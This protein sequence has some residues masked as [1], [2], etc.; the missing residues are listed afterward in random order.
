M[1]K[2]LVLKPDYPH[3]SA[4]NAKFSIKKGEVAVC[5]PDYSPSDSFCVFDTE[6]AALKYV[7]STYYQSFPQ[8]RSPAAAPA[9]AS[10]NKPRYPLFRRVS[11]VPS[12][13]VTYQLFARDIYKF[14][15]QP[16]D[17]VLADLQNLKIHPNSLKRILKCEQQHFQRP[18]VIDTLEKLILGEP[19]TQSE[20]KTSSEE[21]VSRKEPAPEQPA[22]PRAKGIT[23]TGTRGMRRLLHP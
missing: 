9:P 12:K 8:M 3:A 15:A 4:S 17:D 5:P 23:H 16:E 10:P 6:D 13:E 11:A 18:P 19:V 20:Q 14:L 1:P 22:E 7:Q 21:F 2:Y